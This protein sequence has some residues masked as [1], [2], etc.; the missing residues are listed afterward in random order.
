MSDNI[1]NIN[2][3]SIIEN[4]Q[5]YL[6]KI[7][8]TNLKTDEY[9]ISKFDNKINDLEQ[10]YANN[11]EDFKT[12]YKDYIEDIRNKISRHNEIIKD[13]SDNI[14][15]YNEEYNKLNT[16]LNDEINELDSD[17]LLSEDEI[18]SIREDYLDKKITV[19]KDIIKIQER[20]ESLRKEIA[21]LEKQIDKS[22]KE[23]EYS[24]SVGITKNEY[25]DI[26]N[27]LKSK[28]LIEKVL[29]TKGVMDIVSKDVKDRTKEEK[30]KL[31]DVRNSIRDEVAKVIANSNNK[32]ILETIQYLY[33]T[34]EKVIQKETPK[35]IE[36][37]KKDFDNITVNVTIIINKEPVKIT[38]KDNKDYEPQPAP[39]DMIK[40]DNKEENINNETG[41]SEL[42]EAITA[43][44]KVIKSLQ[45][46][47]EK[48]ISTDGMSFDELVQ[49]YDEEKEKLDEIINKTKSKEEVI[50]NKEVI[51]NKETIEKPVKK[52][53]ISNQVYGQYRQLSN[54]YDK[55]ADERIE[56][57]RKHGEDSKEVAD[58]DKKLKDLT[59]KMQDILNLS[60]GKLQDELNNMS[61]SD[62]NK[63]YTKK[64]KGENKLINGEYLAGRETD[65][66]D[67]TTYLVDGPERRPAFADSSAKEEGQIDE[68]SF[69][70]LPKDKQETTDS[71][72]PVPQVEGNDIFG[73]IERDPFPTLPA[74]VNGN[75][76]KSFPALPEHVENRGQN[77]PIPEPTPEPNPEPVPEPTPKPNP[78]NNNERELKDKISVFLDLDNNKKPYIRKATFDRF[79]GKHENIEEVRIDGALCYSITPQELEY[80]EKNK[81]NDISPYDIEYKEVHLGKDYE[82][83]TLY[84]AVD[85][86]N[87]IYATETILK[88]FNIKPDGESIKIYGD[89][90][91][92]IT[93]EQDAEINKKADEHENPRMKVKYVD[94]KIKDI[95][96]EE[97]VVIYKAV[98]DNDQ[99]YTTKDIFD[100][101]GIPVN[102][103]P[104]EI[105]GKPCYKLSPEQDKIINNKAKD[106]KDPIINI[107][108]KPVKIKKQEQT[109]EPHYQEVIRKLTKDLDIKK[110][111]GKRYRASNIRVWQSF[112]DELKAGNYIYNIL[113][114][115][116]AVV[117]AGMNFIRKIASNIML[118][119]RGREVTKEINAR[120]NGKSENK[121]YNLTEADLE[122]L[123]QHYKGRNLRADMNNQ[124]NPIIIQKLREYGLQK[125]NRINEEIKTNYMAVIAASDEIDKQKLKLENMPEGKEKEATKERLKSLYK[126]A[127]KSVR[128]IEDKRKEADEL[129]SS[130]VHGIEEDFKAV[131]SKM[132]YIGLRFSKQH[133]FDNELQD[134]LAD[135]G[136]RINTARANENDKELFESFIDYEKIYYENTNVKESV[137]GKR[138]TGKKWY[139]PLAEMMDYRDDPLIRD[140][141]STVA[142][143]SAAISIANGIITHCIKDQQFKQDVNNDI[144]TT[145]QANQQYHN[146][147]QREVQNI[148]GQKQAEIDGLQAQM[149]KDVRDGFN[150]GERGIMDKSD[151]TYGGSYHADDAILHSE[152]EKLIGSVQNQ[153]NNIISQLHS[154]A[155]T[156]SQAIEMF[157]KA[158]ANL[159]NTINNALRPLYQASKSYAQGHT[160]DYNA[161]LVP[162]EWF[163]NHPKAFV[164]FGNA[165]TAVNQSADSLALLSPSLMQ[166][167]GS[168]PSDLATT[169]AAGISSL[170]LVKNINST[171]KNKNTGKNID[172]RNDELGQMFGERIVGE[173]QEEE[174]QKHK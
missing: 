99:L 87:Q 86:N 139:S 172:H 108:Y 65:P 75:D 45:G 51:Q 161:T 63:K 124:I 146:S 52:E 12:V 2:D 10:A 151:W 62:I 39:K 166:T 18:V 41:L 49:L 129:L 69:R 21:E 76:E 35:S 128:L 154:G 158:E 169:L 71:I 165:I 82:E 156:E 84:R 93:P 120:I 55:L 170:A 1:N 94:V 47:N 68:S 78:E 98:D 155:I 148:Q 77:V 88:M 114:L 91:Y 95:V 33:G 103:D 27:T 31:A 30:Q 130:G 135:A 162:T 134:K 60:N 133:D 29:S 72:T 163:A 112:K 164:D 59:S 118:K 92:K 79:F 123:W 73:N 116:P 74:H 19:S 42:R 53:K 132:N 22:N 138:S 100:K 48:E 25:K 149:Y 173:M 67:I 34:Y 174:K 61:R 4:I 32:S 119:K 16:I 102:G 28:E 142:T 3:N 153:S 58:I 36:M 6:E 43:L 66:N 117:K 137:V 50:D 64:E 57:V 104:T 121:K 54:R 150:T 171:I 122:V 140:L 136:K 168:L 80:L 111:D 17:A 126:V 145:N 109:V 152:A 23:F 89:P 9:D 8:R 37:P 5:D 167:I 159:N 26:M 141:F 105:L 110:K 7:K 97:T 113:H 85:D 115:A 56:L 14:A 160:F 125:V 127:A 46:N 70:N 157:A 96:K 24:S 11:N 44:D 13:I 90:C 20:I 81:D 131:E 143:V 107:I 101:F 147:V 38:G 15:K 83:I 106:S 144:Q 40:E